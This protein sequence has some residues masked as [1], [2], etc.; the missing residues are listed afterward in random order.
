MTFANVLARQPQRVIQPG[1]TK[2]LAVTFGVAGSL[3]VAWRLTQ[4]AL[5]TLYPAFLPG[6][7]NV[8][9]L[10]TPS[11]Q[12]TS[13]HE[14]DDDLT[15]VVEYDI[16]IVGGGTAGCVLASRLSENQDLQVLLIEAGYR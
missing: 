6:E 4:R 10:A 11:K 2:L 5:H 13:R 8:A 14:S 16:V 12:V 3:W 15:N 7:P 9:L 1:N